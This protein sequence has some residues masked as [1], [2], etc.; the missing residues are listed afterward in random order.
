MDITTSTTGSTSAERGTNDS[1]HS[2][3]NERFG[4]SH[5]QSE[6]AS[7]GGERLPDEE[8]VQD[9]APLDADGAIRRDDLEA[10]A[11]PSTTVRFTPNPL[12]LDTS[13]TVPGTRLAQQRPLTATA[14]EFS[15]RRNADGTLL[16]PLDYSLRSH[17]ATLGHLR[18]PNQSIEY[19]GIA[20]LR[21]AYPSQPTAR[22]PPATKDPLSTSLQHFTPHDIPQIVES[23]ALQQRQLINHSNA[24]LARAKQQGRAAI[25]ERYAQR[26]LAFIEASKKRLFEFQQHSRVQM[27]AELLDLELQ[28]RHVQVSPA[29]AMSMMTQQQQQQTTLWTPNMTQLSPVDEQLA[30]TSQAGSPFTQAETPT[31]QYRRPRVPMAAPCQNNHNTL[32][33]RQ[34][35]NVPWLQ[36]MTQPP[37]PQRFW[38]APIPGY[39]VP[40]I[41]HPKQRRPWANVED[42]F[43]SPYA[44]AGLQK[45][46]Q[47]PTFGS[48]AF[49]EHPPNPVANVPSQQVAFDSLPSRDFQLGVDGGAGQRHSVPGAVLSYGSTP[50]SMPG[51][52]GKKSRSQTSPGMLPGPPDDIL[53]SMVETMDQGGQTPPQRGATQA[54]GHHGLQLGTQRHEASATGC[55]TSVLTDPTRDFVQDFRTAFRSNVPA[56]L[57]FNSLASSFIENR[58]LTAEQFYIGVCRLLYRTKAHALAKE[59]T[60][61]APEAWKGKDLGLYHRAMQEEFDDELKHQVDERMLREGP[62]SWEVIGR[63][64]DRKLNVQKSVEEEMLARHREMHPVPTEAQKHKLF[65]DGQGAVERAQKRVCALNEPGGIAP[66]ADRLIVKLKIGG[67]FVGGA[68]QTL[69]TG[70]RLLRKSHNRAQ[71]RNTS[72]HARDMG[73][74]LV[75][76]SEASNPMIGYANVPHSSKRTEKVPVLGN[77]ADHGMGIDAEPS[78][79][80]QNAGGTGQSPYL[81]E[82]SPITSL[83]GSQAGAE[84]HGGFVDEH[85]K[86]VRGD[87]LASALTQALEDATPINVDGPSDSKSEKTP[88]KRGHPGASA[89]DFNYIGPIYET[90]RAVFVRATSRPYVHL[91]CGQGFSHPQDVRMHHKVCDIARQ[92]GLELQKTGAIDASGEPVGKEGRQVKKALHWDAHASCAVGYPDIKYTTVK[93]GYVILDQASADKI[94]RAVQAGLTYLGAKGKEAEDGA[95]SASPARA[96]PQLRSRATTLFTTEA[97]VGGKRKAATDET[98]ARPPPPKRQYVVAGPD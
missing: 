8:Q 85:L 72:T 19:P 25:E 65:I 73:G 74:R 38:S 23:V 40:N 43:M 59:S 80:A 95:A 66:K 42:G 67:A 26:E 10:F 30:P 18:Q 37:T 47:T 68:L 21:G 20:D 94:D 57:A 76:V 4:H 55:T 90:R 51:P 69:D 29:M 91:A 63:V 79:R 33:Q 61:F 62:T 24:R 82:S 39:V 87:A 17:A 36:D 71:P 53:S 34:N 16:N 14:A 58:T 6:L 83:A 97:Q 75:A 64:M 12:S 5:G 2:S 54:T 52:R 60:I 89:K 46:Q 22:A 78:A 92:L 13:F 77:Q 84:V 9:H 45:L 1:G 35:Q 86:D 96:T 50:P 3:S 93:E 15:P 48:A 31:G 11:P 41:N 56:L 81:I 27:Q 7:S 32:S 44:R 49:D 88:R 70:G 98:A 28:Q